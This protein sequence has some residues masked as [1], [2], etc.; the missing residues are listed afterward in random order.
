MLHC[1]QLFGYLMSLQHIIHDTL[2]IIIHVLLCIIIHVLY[3]RNTL[4]TKTN[5]NSMHIV[6]YTILGRIVSN[7]RI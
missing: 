3:I 6:P 1:F 2:Y 5:N 4:F 7:M